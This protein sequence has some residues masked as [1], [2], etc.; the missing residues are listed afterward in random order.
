VSANTPVP[1]RPTDADGEARLTAEIDGAVRAA[2]RRLAAHSRI[3][4]W[5]LW[6]EPDFPRT[7][8]LKV[9]RDA[10]REWVDAEGPLP[11]RDLR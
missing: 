5:R 11:V 3:D 7:H 8:T 2:N 10:V 1:E 6:P 9:R 4:A